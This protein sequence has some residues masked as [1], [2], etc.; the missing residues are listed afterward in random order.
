M[1]Q[2]FVPQAYLRGFQDS[3]KPGFIWVQ[4]RR[5]TSTRLAS[6]E[7]VAQSRDF[8]DEKACRERGGW[9]VWRGVEPGLDDLRTDPRFALLLGS[10]RFPSS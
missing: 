5:E 7:D 10:L 1:G 3:S 4:S 8:Y 6:I 9:T 2:H